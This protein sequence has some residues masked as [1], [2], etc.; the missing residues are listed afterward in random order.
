MRYIIF[1]SLFTF[2]FI[3]CD[4]MDEP[5]VKDPAIQETPLYFP[6][7]GSD[8]WE[9]TLPDSLN[10]NTDKIDE[11]LTFLEEGDTRAFI[12]LK[13]GKI[14]LEKYFGKDLLGLSDFDRDTEWYWAS[15]GKT[16]TSFVVGKAQEEGYLAIEDRTSDYLGQQWTSMDLEKENLI[17]I[18]HQLTMTTGMDDLKNTHSFEPEDLVYVADAGERWSYHNAPYTLLDQVV[19]SAV[20]EDFEDYFDDVLRDPV[21]MDGKWRWLDNN[22]VYFSTARSMARYG[23]LMLNDGVWED[24]PIMEDSSYYNAMINP[25]QEINESY[26]Y[27][28]WLNGQDSYM[29]PQSQFVISGNILPNA[30]KDMYS[31]LG[32][33]NQVLSVIP[34]ENMV[35]VRMGQDP[36][37]SPV[38]TNFVNSYWDL[39][40]D[41]IQ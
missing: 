12:I 40:N 39:L 9:T 29:L 22:H 1:L 27:L 15:A 36:D 32:K 2:G 30:P 26:G 7:I 25:S 41:I 19:E 20:G 34:S 31:A 21:G 10:W 17:T 18:W 6:P 16:L 11:L 8:T 23:L 24:Q 5:I 38:P 3:A 37:D 13:D 33:N 28:W 14:V 4:K 35:V